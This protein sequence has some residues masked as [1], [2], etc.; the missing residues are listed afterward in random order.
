MWCGCQD[1]GWSFSAYTGTHISSSAIPRN[2]QGLPPSGRNSS[3]SQPIWQRATPPAYRR[4][5]ALSGPSVDL[6][7]RSHCAVRASRMIT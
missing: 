6:A 7:T 5:I 1:V 3:P 4:A 2:S